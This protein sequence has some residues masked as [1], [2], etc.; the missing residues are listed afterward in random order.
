MEVSRYLPLNPVRSKLC[1]LPEQYRWSSY[2]STARS[3]MM[4][5]PR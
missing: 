3:R 2:F 1:S 5:K 4:R